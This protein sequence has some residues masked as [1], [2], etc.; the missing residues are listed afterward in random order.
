MY[1]IDPINISGIYFDKTFSP[2][3]IQKFL[4]K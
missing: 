2:N 3:K 4:I 1:F